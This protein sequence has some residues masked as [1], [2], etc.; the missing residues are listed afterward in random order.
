MLRKCVK[1][2]G[3]RTTLFIEQCVQLEREYKQQVEAV[4]ASSKAAAAQLEAQLE[5]A[6]RALGEV[7]LQ[8]MQVGG[9]GWG[10]A[11]AHLPPYG[12]GAPACRS[13]PKCQGCVQPSSACGP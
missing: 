6:R 4:S 8:A 10:G 9:G 1:E 12:Y 2:L 5:D 13:L 11:H 7:E 3:A